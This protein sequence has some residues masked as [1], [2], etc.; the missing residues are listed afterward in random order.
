MSVPL[1]ISPDPSLAFVRHDMFLTD[2]LFL[3]ES[4]RL[5]ISWLPR[6]IPKRGY[7]CATHWRKFIEWYY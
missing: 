7:L 1:S 3:P 5:C 6:T 2:A 4:E